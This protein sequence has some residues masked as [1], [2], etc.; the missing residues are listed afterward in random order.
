M[1]GLQLRQES[2]GRS[3]GAGRVCGEVGGELREGLCKHAC[4]V[5][6]EAR[7]LDGEPHWDAVAMHG[8]KVE[9]GGL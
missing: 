4:G 5:G 8:L 2:A 7:E 6:E 3:R 1:S 9:G